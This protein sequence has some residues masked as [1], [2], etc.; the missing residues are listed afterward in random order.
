MKTYMMF[1]GLMTLGVAGLASGGE[2]KSPLIREVYIDGQKEILAD[3][4]SRTL[5]VFDPDQGSEKPVCIGVCA[6]KWPPYALTAAEAAS[7]QAPLGS[8]AREGGLTQLTYNGRPVYTFFLDRVV[9][10]IKGDGLGG[11]WHLIEL[12]SP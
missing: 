8:I 5:Y 6:E 1:L 12:Q 3:S 4:F 10:D 11:V 7:L 9:S 2:S